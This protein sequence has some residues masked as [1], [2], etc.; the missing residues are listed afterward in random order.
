LILD[1]DFGGIIHEAEAVRTVQN[2]L[3]WVD[4]E[5]YSARQDSRMKLGGFTGTVTFE[6]ELD[7]FISLFQIGEH[8]HIGKAT[9]FGLGKYQ[10]IDKPEQG[11]SS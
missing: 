6:G 11:E 10:I 1:L 4:W 7:P 2:D 9:S 3:R 5:R 8:L